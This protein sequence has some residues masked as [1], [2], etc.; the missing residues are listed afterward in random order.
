MDT[1]NS[2]DGVAKEASSNGTMN[3]NGQA[4]A[5]SNGHADTSHSGNTTEKPDEKAQ[6]KN[7]IPPVN[8][9]GP[10]KL[11]QDLLD[12]IAS[13]KWVLPELTQK[14]K[15]GHLLFTQKGFNAKIIS[16][17][18]IDE[19]KEEFERLKDREKE[20]ADHVDKCINDCKNAFD[21]NIVY[22]NT[23]LTIQKQKLADLKN[24]ETEIVTEKTTTITALEKKQDELV[25]LKGKLADAKKDLFKNWFQEAK[26]RLTEL[27]IMSTDQFKEKRKNS[28]K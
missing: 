10:I 17:S 20:D 16:S 26:E 8:P 11:T 24:R 18:L 12:I 22:Q 13:A 4:H 1:T 15:D 7:E 6:E 19:K 27:N 28:I 5:Q 14:S 3:G 21:N 2:Q 23:L 25:I 9:L